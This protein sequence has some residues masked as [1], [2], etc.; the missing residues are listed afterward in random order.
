ML[1]VIIVALLG[2][3]GAK[4]DYG[5]VTDWTVASATSIEQA[6]ET[7]EVSYPNGQ[8]L[9]EGVKPVAWA[10]P[11]ER[12]EGK[13]FAPVT[14]S[15][16]SH[17]VEVRDAIRPVKAKAP[18][19]APVD[20]IADNAA[21]SIATADVATDSQDIMDK[22]KSNTDV[23]TDK[24]LS[25]FE[26]E[27]FRKSSHEELGNFAIPNQPVPPLPQPERAQPELH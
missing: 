15:K 3:A 27:G 25:Y 22:K 11:E 20:T 12:P 8:Y 19:T 9:R 17:W 18:T 26:K 1:A 21:V 6:S 5:L 24:I 4:D 23:D 16:R 2:Y 10:A 7:P 14:S 13:F